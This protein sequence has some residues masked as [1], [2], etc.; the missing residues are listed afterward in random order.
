MNSWVKKMGG[1]NPW[2]DFFF[3]GAMFHKHGKEN[4]VSF[5]K[6]ETKKH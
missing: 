4:M 5:Q 2:G 6:K 1:W 3:K